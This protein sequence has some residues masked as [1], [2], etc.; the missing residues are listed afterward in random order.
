MQPDFHDD[1]V[2]KTLC[3]K[4]RFFDGCRNVATSHKTSSASPEKFAETVYDAVKKSLI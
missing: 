2:L 1:D 3:C 4:T